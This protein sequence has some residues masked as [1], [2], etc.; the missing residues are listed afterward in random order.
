VS[1]SGQRYNYT[2]TVGGVRQVIRAMGYNP[3]FR[4]LSPDER[5]ARFDRDFSAMRQAGVNTILGWVTEEWDR[6]LLDKAQ[7]R[8]LGVILPYD[9]DPSLDYTNPAVRDAVARDVLGWVSAY[10]DHPAVRMWGIGNEVLHKLV[11]PSWLKLRGDPVLEARAS[12]F[13][14]FYVDLIDRVHQLDPNHP[15]TYRD[16]EDAYVSRMRDALNAGGVSRPW[17]VYGINIYTPRLAS[18]IANW[19]TQG[20]DV[21]L[22]ISEFGP[23]GAGPGDRPKGYRDMWSM[24]RAQPERVLGGAPYVW[25]T[26][27]PEEVDRIF[28]LVDRNGK[29]VD[30]SLAAIGRTFRGEAIAEAP[31][32][33]ASG[34]PQ[35]HVCD[36]G[37]MNLFRQTLEAVRT[38]PKK[39]VFQA[40]APPSI[41]GPLDN[42]PADPVQSRDLRYERVSD[43]DRL[44]WQRMLGYQAEWWVTWNP[45]SRPGDQ[46]ALLISERDGQLEVAYVYRGPGSPSEAGWSC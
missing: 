19:P 23:G 40:T 42:L 36:S 33:A 35:P 11:Y 46:F 12:A 2:Y 6:L 22:L 9:L 8:G 44:A 32:S 43:P 1:V 24:V 7:E 17:F 29:P 5:A 41:M 39:A 16:A 37:I 27:G 15:V 18:V 13:A 26:D 3:K 25:T 30:G 4:Q 10:R 45:P 21:A 20:L 38:D 31:A 14:T 28:G 34:A